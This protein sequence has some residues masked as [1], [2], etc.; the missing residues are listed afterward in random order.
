MHVGDLDGQGVKLQKGTWKGLVT[1]T[2]LRANETSLTGFTVAGTFAQNGWSQSGF[3]CTDG[4]GDGQCTVDSGEF[5]SKDGKA[6]FTVDDV[7]H[8][9]LTYEPADNHD[10]DG[11]SDGTTSQLTK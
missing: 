7:T 6:T 3:T 4:D 1:I 5:P 11:D 8:A 10:P 2:V 9:T